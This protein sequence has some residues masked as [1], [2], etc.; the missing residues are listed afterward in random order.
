VK[1]LGCRAKSSKGARRRVDS[2]FVGRVHGSVRSY[3]RLVFELCVGRKNGVCDKGRKWHVKMGRST[4]GSSTRT[5]N[6]HSRHSFELPN[7]YLSQ[8]T[9]FVCPLIA[10]RTDVSISTNSIDPTFLHA[11]LCQQ[12]L[13][14]PQTYHPPTPPPQPC[15]TTTPP[16]L[17][18]RKSQA[19]CLC[20]VRPALSSCTN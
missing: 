15:R 16:L 1:E 13:L 9:T 14:S 7:S 2:L 3:R 18:P 4:A 10:P 17:P 11:Y 19:L 20:R 6:F 8:L 12:L 5:P